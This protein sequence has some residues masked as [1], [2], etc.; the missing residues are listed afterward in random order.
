MGSMASLITN[1]AIVYSTVYSDTKKKASNLRVT[2]LCAGKSPGTG[3]FPAQMAS[4]AEN[5]SI[6]W[7]H[8]V[9]KYSPLSSTCD[10]MTWS[11]L[12]ITCSLGGEAA[13]HRWITLTTSQWCGPWV[14]PSM[15]I[16][17]NCWASNRQAGELRCS[18]AHL[19]SLEWRAVKYSPWCIMTQLKGREI[20]TTSR[21]TYN[22]KVVAF[23]ME[24]IHF[25]ANEGRITVWV[26]KPCLETHCSTP[27]FMIIAQPHVD[28]GWNEIRQ[29]RYEPMYYL[30]YEVFGN[31]SMTVIH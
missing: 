21:E 12:R 15:S 5:V 2:G 4:D 28:I 27:C 9:V 7:R 6:W 31:Y 24:V 26:I 1:L 16:W 17:T 11:V 22:E 10:V 8:H 23:Y 13:V 25:K 30:K 18:D 29:I 19:T 14:F 3:E 20:K